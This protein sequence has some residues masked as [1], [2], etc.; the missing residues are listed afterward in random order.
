MDTHSTH[1]SVMTHPTARSTAVQVGE[2]VVGVAGAYLAV[3]A[4]WAASG[5]LWAPLVVAAALIAVAA[6]V[7]VRL[8]PRATGFVVG[9][10]PTAV[11]T[12]GLLTALTSVLS[13]LST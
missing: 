4:A 2:F 5:T 10:L 1:H 6:L 3:G 7:E 9:V 12:A 11:V 8:G 13:H